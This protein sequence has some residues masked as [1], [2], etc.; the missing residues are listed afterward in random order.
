MDSGRARSRRRDGRPRI[1]EVARRAGTA[2]ITVSRVLREPDKVAPATRARVMAAVEALG[3]IPNLSASSLASRRSGIVA[4]VVPTVGNSIFTETIQGISDAVT[5]GGLQLL[6]GDSGYSAEREHAL[7]NAVAGRQPE[8]LAIIGVVRR[9]ETR[10]L[11]A[12]L[13]VPVVETW[14]LTDDPVDTV[15]GFS[16]RHAGRAA[17]DFLLAR[18][19]R[20]IGYIGGPDERARARLDGCR[21]ALA[22]AGLPPPASLVIDEPVSVGA[23]RRALARLLDDA[24]EIGAVFFATDVLAVGG[25]LECQRR[26]IAVPGGLALIGLGDRESP[27]E[28]R[29]ALTTVRVP[30]YEIG[31]RAGEIILARLTGAGA[32]RIVD[33]GFSIQE[34]DS[35]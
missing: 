27:D 21:L 23:G 18:G 6:L 19:H 33:L 11:L 7:I 3:Y 8:A 28:L 13:G 22:S 2:A 32:P 9:P 10:V 20:R 5:A 17:A 14:D 29:P 16:N 31:R 30:S 35:A 15:V 26:G 12:N 25:L 24:P 34:R 4:V 1:E